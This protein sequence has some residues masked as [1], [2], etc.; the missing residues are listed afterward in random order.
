M[1]A[2]RAEFIEV[3]RFLRNGH[4]LV[5]VHEM[6]DGCRLAG[7]P[8]Y[9]SF[10]PLRHY[11]LIRE[12]DNPQGFPGIRYSRISERGVEAAERLQ[13]WWRERSLLERVLVRLT[14]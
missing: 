8:V 4:L 9:R 6:A 11:G 1:V 7:A 5:Q 2:D 14:G 10:A 12:V 3:L 13:Q